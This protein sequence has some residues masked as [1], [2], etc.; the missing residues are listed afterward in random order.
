MGMMRTIIDW[1]DEKYDKAHDD[2]ANTK[3][4]R[5]A[6]AAAFIRTGGDRLLRLAA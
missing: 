6:S 4:R 2:F 1:C 3:E 5:K